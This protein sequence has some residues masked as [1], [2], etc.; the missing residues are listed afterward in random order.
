MTKLPTCYPPKNNWI[1]IGPERPGKPVVR[2]QFV[3]SAETKRKR[4]R[5]G[6]KRHV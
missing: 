4:R 6:F 2:P 5:S 3:E 1:W